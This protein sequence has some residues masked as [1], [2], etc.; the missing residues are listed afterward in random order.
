MASSISPAELNKAYHV[1]GITETDLMA[2][3]SAPYRESEDLF[4]KL[5]AKA[6]KNYKRLA[7]DLHPDRNGGDLN[8]T[9]LF[10]LLTRAVK[11]LDKRKAK[12]AELYEPETRIVNIA[13]QS[14]K[15]SMQVNIRKINRKNGLTAASSRDAAARLAKMRPGS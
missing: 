1:L 9:V 5:K 12:S 7:L 2:I 3:V 15:P 4:K 8:K 11:E 14:A 6:R 10:D 13:V